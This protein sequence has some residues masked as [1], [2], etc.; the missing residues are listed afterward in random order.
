M[1]ATPTTHQPLSPVWREIFAMAILLAVVCLVAWPGM[2][3]PRLLDDV[4]Q[5]SHIRSFTS[6]KDC[7]GRDCYGFFR[8]VKNLIFF[9]CGQLPVFPWHALNLSIYL[10]FVSYTHL[11]LPTKRIV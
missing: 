1:T 8:P 9:S 4:D 10:V 2:Q 11:T 3:A 6:W 5:L 7:V